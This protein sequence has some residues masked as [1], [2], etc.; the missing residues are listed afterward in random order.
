MR[1]ASEG[2]QRCQAVSMSSESEPGEL[3]FD[4]S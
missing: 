4:K 3:E 2:R 1:H